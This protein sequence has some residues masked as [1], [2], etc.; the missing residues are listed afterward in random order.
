MP[1][2]GGPSEIAANHRREVCRVDKL[3][4]YLAIIGIED[5]NLSEGEIL[6]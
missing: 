4:N 5:V 1:R 6:Q 2:Q 3:V